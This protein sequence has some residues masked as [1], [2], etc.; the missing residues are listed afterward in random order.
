MKVTEINPNYCLDWPI[1]TDYCHHGI[2]LSNGRFGALLWFQ[3]NTIMVTVNRADYWDH[4]GGM[5]WNEQCHFYRL[6]KL[7]EAG[8][9]AEAQELFQIEQINGQE[10]KPT[11]MPM[12]RFELK[13]KDE[14]QIVSAHLDLF[15]AEASIVCTHP[16]DGEITFKATLLIDEPVLAFSI[17][18]RWLDSITVRPAYA[19]PEVKTYFDQFDIP[20]PR[21]VQGSGQE[22]WIQ[23]LPADPACAV[24]AEASEN[25]LVT[26]H[27]GETKKAAWAAAKDQLEAL[28]ETAYEQLTAPTKEVWSRLWKKTADIRIPD[29]EIGT[30]YYL[31]IYKMLGNSMPGGIA[32]TLQGPWVEE[33]RMAPWS[34]DYH[35]NI[36]V[37]ECLWP[38]YASNHLESLLPLFNMIDSWKPLLAERA[39]LFTGEEDGYQMVHACDDRGKVI[40]KFWTGIIDHANT[41][42]VAQLMWQYGQ[43]AR[44][45]EFLLREVYP[46]MKKTLNVFIRMMEFKD[47]IYT[48]SVSI[49]PEYGGA[50][51]EAWGKNSTFFLT[52]V[53]FLC[54]KIL[55]LATRYQIDSDYAEK[56]RKIREN[57]PPYTTGQG[58]SGEE[59]YLWEGQ[60]LAESH[61]HHSH[62]GG[63]YPFDTIPLED[64][65]HKS[66]VRHSY[67]TWVAKGM[68]AWTGWS[69]PWASIL[70]GRMGGKDMAYTCLK[71]LREFFMMP[72]F[73]TRHNAQY[74][75]FTT[76]TGGDVMQLE[77]AIAASAAVLE[78][79]VQCVQ[80]EI[81]LFPALPDRF[82]DAAFAGIRAEGAFL[83][84]GSRSNGRIDSISIYSEKGGT[85]RLKN[86]FS[87]KMMIERKGVKRETDASVIELETSAGET[88]H[89]RD[90]H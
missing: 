28:K 63:I 70:H 46:F 85:L 64:E 44:D 5:L 54:D 83:I 82:K 26:S 19:F 16:D 88:I 87:G 72:G 36:N 89:M 24:L 38:A 49:S 76:F 74:P 25:L 7:L 67:Q 32:P 59:I 14:L 81:R 18:S 6:R 27:Y 80:G 17:N 75:G 90:F 84:S 10:K 12:G 37:Q 33:H 47:G 78:L 61:R 20:P 41:S 66:L 48:L 50:G 29:E 43:Y 31:G 4:R 30:M 11:R 71:L 42:W 40:G 57:L 9:Y 68:G 55:R 86:P 23:E 21:V 60:P 52:N 8:A 73:A 35:F 45:E 3:E 56:V 58:A 39:K 1:D 65:K 34:G 69:M 22:G 13:L 53:H 2:P 77:A 79:F 51:N 15:H 62:L